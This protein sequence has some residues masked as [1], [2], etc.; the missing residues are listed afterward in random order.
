MHQIACKVTIRYLSGIPN[1]AR[2]DGRRVHQLIS[3]SWK[4]WLETNTD[5]TREQV[6]EHMRELDRDYGRF[7][8]PPLK[9]GAR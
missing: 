9:K 1:E 5:P 3:G 4:K 2:I 6:L 8:V 7:F